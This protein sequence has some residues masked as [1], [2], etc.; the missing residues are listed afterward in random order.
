MSGHNSIK[1]STWYALLAC[2]FAGTA[3][4][5]NDAPNPYETID[6][7][8][9]LPAGRIWGATSA[10]YPANDGNN[11]WIAERCGANLCVESDVAGVQAILPHVP[12]AHSVMVRLNYQQHIV[13]SAYTPQQVTLDLAAD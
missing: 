1:R 5:Q 10:I 3:M 4:A 11:I 6:D 8:A 13:Q 12:S 7:W 9:K 2:A